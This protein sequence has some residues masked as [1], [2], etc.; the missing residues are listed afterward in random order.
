LGKPIMHGDFLKKGA[1]VREVTRLE[2]SP[3]MFCCK[4]DDFWD[5]VTTEKKKANLMRCP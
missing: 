4:G 3:P 2:G 1:I 5:H